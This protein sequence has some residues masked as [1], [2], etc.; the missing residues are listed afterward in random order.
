MVRSDLISANSSDCRLSTGIS[1]VSG[2]TYAERYKVA[3][4]YWVCPLFKEE[5]AMHLPVNR[6]RMLPA[7]HASSINL[8]HSLKPAALRSRFAPF[9]SVAVRFLSSRLFV[10]RVDRLA[11]L[12]TDLFPLLLSIVCNPGSSIQRKHFEAGTTASVTCF[13]I[14]A[15][16]DFY[17]SFNGSDTSISTLFHSIRTPTS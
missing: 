16:M 12:I 1:W 17:T 10:D 13:A 6:A 9:A 11:H 5:G 15:G 8:L 7:C 3:D 4:W 2:S 14:P